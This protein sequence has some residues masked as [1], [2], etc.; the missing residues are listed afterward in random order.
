MNKKFLLVA[1]FSAA[2][3]L[4]AFAQTNLAEGII[5]TKLEPIVT[6]NNIPETLVGLTDGK[7]DNI[8]LMPEPSSD[9]ADI[10]AFSLDLGSENELGMIKIYWEGA[11][12]S[13]FIIYASNDNENWTAICTKEGLGQR[14]EDELILQEGTKA[15]YIKFVAS[16]AVNYGW[17]V[18]MREFQVFKAEA[19]A[20]TSITTSTGFVMKDTA[21]DLGIK[22]SDQYGSDFT[23]DVTYTTDNGTIT[24]GKLSA[25]KSGR[26]TITATDNKNNTATTTIYVLDDTMAPSQPSVSEENAYGIYSSYSSD[27]YVHWM[28]WSGSDLTM[29]E[30][31]LGNQTVKP[32]AGGNKVVIGQKSN[33]TDEG[34]QWMQFDNSTAKYTNVS[35]DIFPT[36]DFQGTLSIEGTT[37]NETKVSL[38]AGQWNTI[39]LTGIAGEGNTI[40]C[41]A[42]A[43]DGTFAPM[44]V[45]NIYLYKLAADQIVIS[46]TANTNGFYTVSGNISTTNV[47]DL[48][49]AEG[50]AFDLT[51]ATIA[52][53]VT[54]IEFANPNA[55]V[56]V[57]G[58]ATDFETAN[59]LSETNNV[60]T[61]D[62]TY[63]FAAKTLKFDDASPICTSISIDA[64]KG[65]TTGFEYTRKIAANAWVTTTPLVGADI[66]EGVEAYELDTENSKENNV[67]FKKAEN[68]IAN[69]PYILH[70]TKSETVEFGFKAEGGDFN[71]TIAVGSIEAANVTFHGNYVAKNG[72]EVEYGLQK[73]TVGNDNVL[74]FKKVGTGATIGTFRAYFTLNASQTDAKA[75][76]ITFTNDGTTTGIGDIHT[77]TNAKKANG[78]YTLDGRKV[79]EST[80]LDNMPK[81][82]YIVNG[83]K[84]VK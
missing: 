55:L 56:M 9:G 59:K 20:L 60:I 1:A 41:I 32:L 18:K 28:T 29:E 49:T 75:Y 43:T 30:I 21:T 82:V 51:N 81:G 6:G 4:G 68:L 73:A 69:Y 23:G 83:K 52:E 14:T 58:N 33:K 3:N 19:T 11:A 27:K 53:D 31:T 12:T 42:I 79:S 34:D 45:S 77:E 22:V 74:T 80:S 76:N 38:K 35:M 57:A 47:G 78:I 44:L 16:K 62:G 13:D 63:F 50:I 2:M 84:I 10:Q 71:P 17:G 54:K 26:C 66:P 72:T 40:K 61:T 64:S 7:M 70:N 25:T 15:R 65:E 39:E 36:K 8:Y 67:T 46:K 48:K 24:D 37:N 5:P